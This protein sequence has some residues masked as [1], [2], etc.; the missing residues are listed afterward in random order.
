MSHLQTQFLVS[1]LS[2]LIVRTM[3]IKPRRMPH[4]IEN[5]NRP[6]RGNGAGKLRILLDRHL[7]AAELRQIVRHR[8]KQP[9]QSLFI[10]QH[11]GNTRHCFRH[12]IDAEDGV[13]AHGDAGIFVSHPP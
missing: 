10:E 8:I 13:L 4:Q 11:G 5:G 9:E 6:V 3:V 1:Q 12:G 2:V 7:H